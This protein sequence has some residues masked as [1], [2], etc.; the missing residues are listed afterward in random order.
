MDY[1]KKAIK[2]TTLI[3]G[4]NIIAAFVGYLIRMI[5]ARNLSPEEYGLFFA[6][7][8]LI[9]ILAI[10]KYAGLTSALIKF[11]PE[12]EVH[13]KHKRIRTAIMSVFY[14]CLTNSIIIGGIVLLLSDVLIKFYFKN[15]LASSILYLFIIMS[16][17]LTFRDILRSSFQG[18]QKTIPFGLMY[19]IENIVIL[20]LISIS[21]KL[22]LSII[23]TTICYILSLIIVIIA[24]LPWLNKITGIFKEKIFISKKISSKLIKF[25]IPLIIGGIG[26]MIILYVDTLILTYFV[27]LS[28]VGI[29]NVVVPTAM[30]L[31]FIAVSISQIIFPMISEL[32]TRN[33]DKHLTTGVSL[34]QRYSFIIIIPL[35]LIMFSFPKLIIRIMFGEM[36]I[37]GAKTLQILVISMI[38]LVLAGINGNILNGLGKQKTGMKIMLLGGTINLI[39]NFYFIPKYGI[40]GAAI[41]SL[42]SYFIIMVLTVGMVSYYI[43]LKFPWLD[44]VKTIFAGGIFILIIYKL[45]QLLTL[46][47][48]LEAVVC[49]L[50]AGFIYIGISF[51]IK[52][53][54]IKEI[55]SFIR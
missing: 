11:I 19:L 36:Y 34:L 49:V 16:I 26:G 8:T 31:N 9:N 1:L 15:A 47:I 54:T 7:F 50:I 55:K 24:F 38:F 39:T 10:F 25:G 46:N 12:F 13:K 20:I 5:L 6:I 43:K 48:Y 4:I 2:N 17:L 40:I 23:G 42:I 37:S 32:K 52:T 35:A 30:M 3:F 33:L 29:Y 28:E 21:F 45:K 53:I 44:W 27:P 18:L 51:L 14:I 41:T 22:N